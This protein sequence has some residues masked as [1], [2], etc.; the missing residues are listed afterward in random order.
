[1][2]LQ[3]EVYWLT[4]GLADDG[5]FSHR[6]GRLM[7]AIQA[8]AVGNVWQESTSF[9]LFRSPLSID[10]LIADLGS[11]VRSD[12]DFLL[13]GMPFHKSARLFGHWND[14]RVRNLMHFAELA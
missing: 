3:G 5:H 4:F 11:A 1:M 14:D 2:A 13:L 8:A 12:R 7:N 6:H 10:A 9:C